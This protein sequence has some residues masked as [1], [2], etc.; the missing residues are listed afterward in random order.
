MDTKTD[1]LT[2]NCTCAQGEHKEGYIPLQ[3][4]W[5]IILQGG[6][7]LAQKSASNSA[8]K[9]SKT[10]PEKISEFYAFLFHP[11]KFSCLSI[12]NWLTLH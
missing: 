10:L 6:W 11:T 3:K 4:E 9:D 12:K 5:T 7:Y 1:Y 2:M 8:L